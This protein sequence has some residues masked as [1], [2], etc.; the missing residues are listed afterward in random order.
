MRVVVGLTGASGS[1][2]TKRMV[3]FLLEL[4]VQVILVSTE[5]GKK[6]F[7]YEIELEYNAWI[8]ELYKRSDLFQEEDND[9]MFAGIA[10]GSFKTDA[11]I[12]LPASMG[13]T[14]QIAGGITNNLLTRA[15][16][17]ALKER[18]P[19]IIVPRETPMNQIHLETLLK[20]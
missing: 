15:A 10:S 7:E 1:I 11:V 13:T 9:N 6:V 2:Y 18:R 5:N 20:I 19:L 14:G 12:I 8:K 17:V 4:E 3:E 16:D